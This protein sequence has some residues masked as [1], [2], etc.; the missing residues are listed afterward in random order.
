MK[1]GDTNLFPREIG[2][3]E[4]VAHII[5]DDLE[6]YAM[7]TLPDA[8]LDRLEEHLLVCADCRDRLTR[9]DVL[10]A[11][12]RSAAAKI[13]EQDREGNGGEENIGKSH[14]HR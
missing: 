2:Y 10:V 9:T 11:A 13:R 4:V 5:E 1:T 3:R 12:M 6:W 14:H 8:E 7:R